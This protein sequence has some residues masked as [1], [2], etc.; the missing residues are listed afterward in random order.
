MPIPPEAIGLRSSNCRNCIGIIRSCPHLLQGVVASGASS[1]GIKIFAPQPRHA[2]MR[3]GFRVVSVATDI[4]LLNLTSE[5]EPTSLMPERLFAIVAPAPNAAAPLN[6]ARIILLNRHKTCQGDV[7]SLSRT[8]F[9]VTVF[10][11]MRNSCRIDAI[12]RRFAL[13]R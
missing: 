8:S 4:W 2:T 3:S 10:A 7:G 5:F 1:P 13:D 11:H 12:S 9:G 6:P